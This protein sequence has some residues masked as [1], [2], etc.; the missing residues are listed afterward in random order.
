MTW[1]R[2]APDPR[3]VLHMREGVVPSLRNN[4]KDSR[5]NLETTFTVDIKYNDTR[6]AFFP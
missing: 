3:P 2:G 1:N 6:E 5:G 4:D